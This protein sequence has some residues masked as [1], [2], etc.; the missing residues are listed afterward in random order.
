MNNLKTQLKNHFKCDLPLTKK[1]IRI[2]SSCLLVLYMA[3]ISSIF[4]QLILDPMLSIIVA[5]LLFV[6]SAYYFIRLITQS[7]HSI[8]LYIEYQ[9][10]IK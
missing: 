3:S 9:N 5:F 1:Q 10:T 8:E 4:L 7:I 2:K 6:Y